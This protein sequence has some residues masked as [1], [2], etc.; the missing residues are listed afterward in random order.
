[1]RLLPTFRRALVACAI[2][3]LPALASAQAASTPAQLPAPPLGVTGIVRFHADVPSKFVA[4]RHVEVWLPPGYERGTARYPVVYMHDGQNVFAPATSY[5]KIDWAVDEV[6]TRLVAERRVRPAIVVGIWNTPKRFEEYMP[7]GAIDSARIR[8]AIAAGQKPELLADRYLRFMVEE[9]KPF[10]DRTYRTRP[11]RADTYVMGSSMGGLISL[12]AVAQYPDV[13]GG[14]GCISTHWPAVDGV[15]VDW[16]RTHVPAPATH[17]LWFDHG[18]ATLDTLYAPY[19][20]RVDSIV[21]AGGYL[22][23]KNWTTR[24]YPGAE[25]AER[26]WRMRVGDALEFLLGK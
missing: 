13:F 21:R 1:M 24:V 12:Y 9:L 3:L 8:Q 22:A 17:R 26:A 5:T 19:Q 10:I 18:T 15:T 2:P 25:H 23:G 4:A 14:C 7:E 16:L 11:G 6:M 20:Q